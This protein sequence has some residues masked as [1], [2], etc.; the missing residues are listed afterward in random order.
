MSTSAFGIEHGDVSKADQPKA[1]GG[2]QAAG[3]FFAGTHGAV[4]G[5]KGKKLKAVGSE[6]GHTMAGSYGGAAGGAAAG[7]ALGAAV[8]HGRPSAKVGAIVGYTAG[9]I[10]GG[11]AGARRGVNSNQAKG[12]YKREAS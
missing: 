11:I 12:R 7:A 5:K 6:V 3:Y 8:G 9:G 4:A 2:R 1:S 10:G